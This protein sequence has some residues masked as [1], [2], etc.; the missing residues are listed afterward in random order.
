VTGAEDGVKDPGEAGAVGVV[1][2]RV[3]GSEEAGGVA[4]GGM[5]EEMVDER[6]H[7]GVVAG[8][9]GRDVG[10]GFGVAY[11]GGVDEE[12]TTAGGLGRSV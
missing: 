6:E 1:R 7:S 3:G 12:A 4:F 5:G 8:G 9:E 11:D 2:A 10:M